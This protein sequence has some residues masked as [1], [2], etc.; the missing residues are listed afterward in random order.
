MREKRASSFRVAGRLA[1][2]GVGEA[3]RVSPAFREKQVACRRAEAK[4]MWGR[5][6]V[7]WEQAEGD[8]LAVR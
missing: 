6:R 8:E 4:S 3:P 2:S 5:R 7:R 1:V